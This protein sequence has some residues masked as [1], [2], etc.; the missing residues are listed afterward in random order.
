M[1]KIGAVALFESKTALANVAL[2]SNALVWYYV[3][4]I[5]FLQDIMEQ[6]FPTVGPYISAAIWGVHFSSIIIS[7]LVGAWITNR[8]DRRKL[9]TVWMV[10]T[11][12]ASLTLLL[13]GTTNIL[14]VTLIGLALGAS[15]G[16]GMPACI[17]Q[18]TDSI[19]IDARGRISGI[20][21]LASGIGIFAFSLAG[22]T[23]FW[24]LGILLAVWRLCGF[25]ILQLT[26][27]LFV[28][29]AKRSAA[30]Y[31]KIIAQKSFALYFVPWVMFSIINYLVAPSSRNVGADSG[32]ITLIQIGCMGV[33]A[34]IGGFFLDTVGRKRIAV[35]GF[36][37][38]GLGTAAL[39]ISAKDQVIIYFNSVVD[40]IAWGLL[41]VLFILTIWGDLSQ[42]SPSDKYYAIGVAP[43][44]VSKFLDLAINTNNINDTL[45][46]DSALF[47]FGA[48]FLFL[49]VLPLVYAPETLPEK[50]MK[51][52]DLRSYAEKALKQVQKETGKDQKKG[53]AKEENK[54][55]KPEEK[56]KESPEDEEARK[57]AEKYY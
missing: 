11:I 47:S 49:A 24:I 17:S 33:A 43:F 28:E 44:F 40:G 52:R 5:L 6:V 31:K 36:V 27:T 4:L 10:A 54:Q 56:P 57:L 32:N 29:K 3:V 41:L 16:F 9:L 7:A 2:I 37:L 45:Q 34:I 20:T 19:P 22:I 23:E 13:G 12:L 35:L 46:G 30:T 1:V 26:K 53:K 14:I 18:F 48:F 21:F 50:L 55:E 15:L 8:V 42:D 38:L 25:A 51:D 39:G